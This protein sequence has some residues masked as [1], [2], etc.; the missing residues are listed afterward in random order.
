[1]GEID[2]FRRGGEWGGRKC[3]VGEIAEGVAREGWPCGAQMR[4]NEVRGPLPA[5]SSPSRTKVRRSCDRRRVES[6]GA[7]PSL[8]LFPAQGVS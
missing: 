4:E 5:A 8:C 1:M 6:A 7:Y 2:Q 3:V